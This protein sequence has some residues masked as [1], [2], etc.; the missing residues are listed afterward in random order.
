MGADKVYVIQTLHDS[1]SKKQKVNFML[2]YFFLP[3][4]FQIYKYMDKFSYLSN[5]DVSSAEDMYQLYLKDN[6]SVD[7]GWQRFFE[8][9][10]FARNNFTDAG[11]VPENLKKEFNVINLINSY[12]SRGHLFTQTNPVRER[13]KYS[14][15][16][17][18]ENFGLVQTDLEMVFQ[19]GTQIGIGPSKLKD[20]VA[21]LNQTYCHSIGA[22]YM[23]IRTPAIIDWL[24]KNSRLDNHSIVNGVV[25]LVTP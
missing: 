24:Q 5:V 9:F 3:L 18:I 7:I 12:R 11:Q 17:D 25:S 23:Y 6:N 13:R 1:Y 14:P 20:I 21:H 8:G 19:A 10:E 15:T 4:I 2:T 22:E 16:L